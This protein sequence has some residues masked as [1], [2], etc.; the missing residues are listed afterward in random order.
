M[1]TLFGRD[2]PRRE[3]ARRVGDVSQLLGVELLE[4][5]DGQERGVRTLRFR[6]GGGLAFDLMVDRA[7]D[8][9]ALELHGVPLGWRSPTGFRSPWLHEHDAEAGL[10]WLRSFSGLVS[11]CGLDH[12]MGPVEEDAGHYAYPYRSRV[13]HGLHGRVA[14]TPARLLGYGVS[15]EGERCVLWA[16]GEIRQATMFGEFLV[17]TRR[18]EA[19][20]G[21]TTVTVRDTVE[22]RGFRPTPHAMLYHVNVGFPVVDEGA[23]LV[24][25]LVRTRHHVHDPKVTDVGPLEQTAPRAGFVEQVYEHEVAAGEDGTAWAALVNPAFR[26]PAGAEG[27]GLR[28]AWDARAMPAFYQWQNL[29]EGDYVVGLEPATV[30][31]GSREDWKARGELRFLEHGESVTYGLELTPVLGREA[32]GALTTAATMPNP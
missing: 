28:V 14:Y 4:H 9:G 7:M 24:A 27:L 11:T 22:N 29:Q 18:V 17:H 3:F 26:H 31:A 15:W 19:E 1:P 2:L 8:V 21:G 25:P 12:V 10:G 6:T 32:I 23:K 16:E 30:L 20:A 13:R 5:V